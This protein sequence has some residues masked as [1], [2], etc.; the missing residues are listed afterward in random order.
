MRKKPDLFLEDSILDD[1]SKSFSSLEMPLS[2]KAFNLITFFVLIVSLAIIGR[3]LFLNGVKGEFYKER[4]LANMS[5]ITYVPAERG[6]I[7]DRF[8]KPLVSNISSFKVVLKVSDFFKKSDEDR[9][10][11]LKQITSILNLQQGQIEEWVKKVD[12]E[13]QSVMNIAYDLTIEQ[14]AKFKNLNFDDIEI[15]RDFSRKYGINGAFSHI[16]GYVGVVSVDDLKKNNDLFVNDFTGKSGLEFF[17]DNELRG[18]SGEII[19]YR[20]AKNESFGQKKSIPAKKGNNLYLT[21][22]SDLQNFFHLRL[23]SQLDYLGRTSGAGIIINPSNGEIL[24]LVSLPSFNNNK[25]T[26]NLLVDPAKP[27]FNRVV[28]GLYSPAS[29]IKPLV[30]IAALNEKVI[31]P[32]KEIFSPGYLDIPNPYNPDKPSRFLDWKPQGWVNMYSA[33]ARSSDVYFYILG[34]GFP[35]QFS[36]SGIW[37]GDENIGG[38]GIQRLRNYWEKFGLNSKTGIDLPGEK[39]GFIPNAEEKEKRTDTPWRLGDT[40]N[41]SIGQ[42]DLVVTPIELINYISS[43]AAGGKAFQP[44]LLKKVESENGNVTKEY[45]PKIIFDNSYLADF[46]AEAQKGMIDTSKKSY[47]TANMLSDLPFVVASKTGSAQI[48][49]NTKINAF[50]VGYNLTLNNAEQ[51]Q[52]RNDAE[53][54]IPQQ[55]AVL[56]LIENAREGSMNAVP[57]AK[58]V[59]KWYYENRLKLR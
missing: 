2:Q 9:K 29:T 11:E 51:N 49:L 14:V 23:K 15:V 33:I 12:L 38:L 42:G 55:I 46:I 6:L 41:V 25:I 54:S 56:V 47:G 24:S 8:G 5:K 4:S 30:A 31:T 53:N 17:Y 28:S 36:H 52:S 58:D 59:F 16:L 44:T 26:S 34:G 13:R 50:Y 32:T 57:V 43:I 18:S 48:E 45:N 35:S 19:D 40:Y 7:F 10:N 39:S 1:F 20:N 27:L 22:D 37:N 3:L 21:I